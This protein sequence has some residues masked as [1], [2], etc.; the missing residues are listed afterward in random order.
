MSRDA[1]Q[2]AL[3]HRF[4]Q[5]EL[6]ED[7]LRHRSALGVRAGRQSS[8]ERLEFVG[9]R[10]LALVVAEWLAERFPAEREGDWGKRLSFL[11]SR[12]RVAGVAERLGLGAQLVVPPEESRAG[13]RERANVLADAMEA[14][15]GAIFLDAGLAPARDFIRNAWAPILDGMAAPPQPAKTALQEWALKHGHGLPTY[16]LLAAD[17]PSHAP[18][19]HVSVEVGG[20]RAEARGD[21]KRAAEQ[22][23]AALV[24]AELRR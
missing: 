18:R 13:V 24:L 6:L 7:A 8:N 19:F 2:D 4:A 5:P 15:L 3:G 12:E 10:V 14:V 17:G 11:V 23:A 1:L 21:S 20:R 16:R 9:D 22:E